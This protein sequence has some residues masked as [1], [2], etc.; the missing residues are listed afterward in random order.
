MKKNLIK[1][2]KTVLTSAAALIIGF[3]AIAFPFRLFDNLSA[4]AMRYLF[5]GEMALYFTVGMVFL[6]IKGKRQEEKEKE[7]ARRETK[8]IKFEQ[9]QK[10]YYDFAA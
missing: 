8:R 7:K 5:I 10:D 2:L 4:E 6:F 9:A 1:V 3:A